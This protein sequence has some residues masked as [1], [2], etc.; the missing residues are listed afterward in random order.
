MARSA[1]VARQLESRGIRDE[2]VLSA[3]RRVPRHHFVDQPK[4]DLAYGDHPLP[5]GYGQTISQPYMVA[6]MIELCELG[7]ADRAL[8]VGAGCGYQSAVLAELCRQVF[9]VEIVAE[10]AQ[11][12]AENLREI[13]IDNVVVAHM[14]GSSGWADHAPF[15]AILVAAGAPAVPPPLFDQ[16]A[17]GGTMVV[18]VGQTRGIQMLQI[19]QRKGDEWSTEYDTPCRFVDLQG[20]YGWE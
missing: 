14:D 12:A 4:W 5:I 2:R 19:H 13:G 18:P 15:D 3:M 7:E 6:R 9:A 10:L 8:E 16:L 11:Q 1:M 17:E 20:S